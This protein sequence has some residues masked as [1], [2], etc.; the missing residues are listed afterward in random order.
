MSETNEFASESEDSGPTSSADEPVQEE[1]G[2]VSSQPSP[3]LL[4]DQLRPLLLSVPL[5]TLLT[6]VVFPIALAA[7][8]RLL[9]PHQS[10]GSL[11]VR[12]QFVVGSRLIG[13]ADARP[14]DFHPRSS[15]AGSGYD[16]TA[17]GGTNLGPLNPRLHRDVRALADNYRRLNGLT[18]SALVPID[19][20][21]RSGSG[22]DPHI[23]PS[24]AVLQLARVARMRHLN[25]QTVRRLV[26][27][28][29]AGPQFG[30]LG[31]SRVSVL[32]LNLALDKMTVSAAPDH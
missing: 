24:N 15:A 22:L 31:S 29:T 26:A 13:Q 17:S 3:S 9:F 6:G 16:A 19:A 25:E 21:T 23:S 14:G 18:A 2:S 1:A 11:V 32:E 12:D 8:A 27:E 28:H 20:V 30:W 10:E 5:L 4:L 7:P